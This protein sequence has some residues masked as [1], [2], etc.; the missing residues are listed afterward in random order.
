MP[1]TVRSKIPTNFETFKKRL[2][3]LAS[4]IPHAAA[5]KKGKIGKHVF[6]SSKPFGLS[7]LQR[8]IEFVKGQH[9]KAGE[10]NLL[11]SIKMTV[12]SNYIICIR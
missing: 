4:E 8:F 11:E 1:K 9:H 2:R 10:S 3:F 5:I 6:F 7:T 12:L